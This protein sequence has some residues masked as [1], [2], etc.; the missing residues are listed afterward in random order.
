[1]D[2]PEQ[3]VLTIA[4]IASLIYL[5]GW[6]SGTETALTHLNLVQIAN[7]KKRDVKNIK[8]IMKLRKKITSTLPL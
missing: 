2:N 4:F 7:M 1:M 8:F 6:F 5:S 3:I